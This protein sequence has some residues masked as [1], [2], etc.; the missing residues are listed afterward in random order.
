MIQKERFMRFALCLLLGLYSI[1][2]VSYTLATV[3]TAEAACTH[4]FKGEHGFAG[5]KGPNGKA[6]TSTNRYVNV[7][8]IGGTTSP[9]R[10]T[11]TDATNVSAAIN[12]AASAWNGQVA[13]DNTSHT[14]YSV[15]QTR[16]ANDVNVY[17]GMVDSVPGNKNACGGIDVQVD[18]NGNVTGAIMLL[19]KDA[20]QHL[21]PDQIAKIIEHE[22]GHFFGLADI[23]NN[24]TGQCESIMDKANDAS[25]T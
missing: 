2:L 21:T 18:Q 15:R 4:C 17:V 10:F 12:T 6:S 23:G 8:Y 16:S 13:E 5:G 22:L 25:C 20:V 19:K 11:G 9:N 7:G 1:G 3:L 24:S 14:N